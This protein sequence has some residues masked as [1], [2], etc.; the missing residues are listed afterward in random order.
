M[1]LIALELDSQGILHEFEA[2]K[3][4][5]Y[6]LKFKLICVYVEEILTGL[7]LRCIQRHLI[8]G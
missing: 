1:P 8:V 3:L 7:E 5:S 2:L 4:S 6:G